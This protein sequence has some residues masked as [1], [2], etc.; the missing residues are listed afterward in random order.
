V[1]RL[2]FHAFPPG[3]GGYKAFRALLSARLAFHP[4]R[5]EVL[6]RQ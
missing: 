5:V 4:D 3:T 2:F 1:P 6:P